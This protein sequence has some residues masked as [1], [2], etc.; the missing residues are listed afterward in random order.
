MKRQPDDERFPESGELCRGEI[1]DRILRAGAYSTLG[2]ALIAPNIV[3]ALDKPL[4]QLDNSLDKRARRR[5]VMRTVYY[6]KSRGYLVGE[7]EH[8]L[9]LTAKA[10]RRLA[11]MQLNEAAICPVP[12]WDRS[13]RIIVYDIPQ[14]SKAARQFIA[15]YLR[16]IGCFQLQKS[17]WITPFDCRESVEAV[18]VHTQCT[19]YITYFE[20][21]YLANESVILRRF[22]KKYPATNFFSV[23]NSSEK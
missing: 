21:H 19:Q 13:W 4:K 1:V 12:V 8:G 3:M 10:M 22:A 15:A 23:T 7:Y 6:M 5:E 17:T 9:E 20:A 18:G 2:L 16:R 11:K 14:G